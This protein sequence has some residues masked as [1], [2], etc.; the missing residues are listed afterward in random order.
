LPLSYHSVK[1]P[2][3]DREA[4]VTFLFWKGIFENFGTPLNMLTI[5]HSQ[6]DGHGEHIFLSKELSD[7]NSHLAAWKFD[8][9][10]RIVQ[11]LGLLRLRRTL[12]SGSTLVLPVKC[13]RLMDL[14]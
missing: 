1:P 9:T 13:T 6:T 4:E 10:N 7:W 12:G 2:V 14:T 5:Y 3:T 8:S 11:L